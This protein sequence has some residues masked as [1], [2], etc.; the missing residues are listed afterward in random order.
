MDETGGYANFSTHQS[1]KATGMETG[2]P[3]T[4]ELL[5]AESIKKTDQQYKPKI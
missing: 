1:R 3:K 5:Y 2:I 4:G